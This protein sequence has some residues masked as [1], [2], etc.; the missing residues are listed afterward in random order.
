MKAPRVE[1]GLIQ[2]ASWIVILISLAC[3]LSVLRGAA[4]DQSAAAMSEGHYEFSTIHF[5]GAENLFATE[6]HGINN[7]DQIV[8]SEEGIAAFVYDHGNYQKLVAPFSGV[9]GT[10]ALAINEAGDIAGYYTS[11]GTHAFVKKGARFSA[12]EI[13]D[14]IS[15]TAHCINNRGEIVGDCYIPNS[16]TKGILGTQGFLFRHG[17]FTMITP[18]AWPS[19]FTPGLRALGINDAGHI[20]GSIGDGSEHGFLYIDQNFQSIV[21]PGAKR[22]FAQ[23][24]NNHD[25]IVGYYGSENDAHGFLFVRNRFVKIDIPGATRT[26]V[27]GINDA[28]R[29]VG[30][31]ENEKQWLGFVGTPSR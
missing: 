30:T 18:P 2:P 22:T 21:F 29:I 8:G 1:T 28:G 26:W 10:N 13:P 23:S 17:Q 25:Q 11:L 5:P 12:I 20:V 4:G 19:G 3:L 24:I 16:S 9:L 31:F 27:Y 6:A 7:H 15:T 14:S